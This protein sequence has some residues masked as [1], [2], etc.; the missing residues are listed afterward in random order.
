MSFCGV[1][2][3]KIHQGAVFCPSCG[4]QVV[5]AASKQA[6]HMYC[7][8]C[9]EEIPSGASFCP[10]C[11]AQVVSVPAETAAVPTPQPT[12]APLKKKSVVLAAVLSF[13]IAGL[14]HFYLGEWK[15]GGSWLIGALILGVILTYILPGYLLI[16]G[17]IIGVLSA[18]DA[19]KEALNKYS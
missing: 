1:C 14:G 2:G 4:A 10:S 11:G 6:T 18:F 3:K 12:V 15:R 13:L 5:T 16:A 8:R 19:R 9:G 7:R 17:L